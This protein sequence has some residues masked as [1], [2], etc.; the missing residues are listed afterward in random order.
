MSRLYIP[1]KKRKAQS[2]LTRMV[3][4]GDSVLIAKGN[5]SLLA[6]DLDIPR[7]RLLTEIASFHADGF[8]FDGRD[9]LR[10]GLPTNS[11]MADA[12]TRARVLE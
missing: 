1:P 6:Y 4:R 12:I 10:I 2:Q 5:L 8:V 9:S 11:A 3:A 7:D